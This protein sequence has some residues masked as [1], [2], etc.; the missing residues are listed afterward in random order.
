MSLHRAAAI[1]FAAL[2]LALAAAAPR[3][4]AAELVPVSLD[5]LRRVDGGAPVVVAARGLEIPVAGSAALALPFPAQEIE[6]D[7]EAAAG[8]PILLSWASRADRQFRPYGPPWRYAEVPRGRKTL[9]LDLRIAPGWAPAAQPVLLLR[10]TGTVAV[11][12]VRALA[13][14]HSVDEARD[15]LDR[16]LR[17]APESIG[18]TTINFLT[19]A[20]WRA[21]RGT[22]L[23]DVVAAAA[24][25]IFLAL[26]AAARLRGRRVRAGAAAATACLVALAAFDAHFLVRFLPMANLSF[27]PDPEARIRDNY[28]FDPEFGALAALARATLRPDERVGT[29]GAPRDWFGPQTLCFAVA[30]RPCAIVKPGEPIHAGISGVGRLRSE[31]IDAIVSLRGGPLPDGFAPVAEVDR[32]AVVARRR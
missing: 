1:S 11:H 6:L 20:Y 31:E 24:L 7:L 4:A 17:W 27:Q 21:S 32:D 22:W 13:A 9:R 16:A 5:A 30:P 18:H 23:S 2:A 26:L 28:Y 19:P 12:G 14:P 25:A 29:M 10:G 8:G 15:A 3:S